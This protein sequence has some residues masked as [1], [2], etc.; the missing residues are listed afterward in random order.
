MERECAIGRHDALRTLESRPQ[1]GL[2]LCPTSSRSADQV[3]R[4]R[5]SYSHG[6]LCDFQARQPAAHAGI[7]SAGMA[8]GRAARFDLRQF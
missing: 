8:L 6:P 1:V 7:D 3:V 5:W 4:R 2:Y